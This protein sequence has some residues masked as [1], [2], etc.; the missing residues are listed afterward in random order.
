MIVISSGSD[1]DS[2]IEV[3]SS[4]DIKV[5]SAPPRG[6][7]PA[8][9][10]RPNST[11]VTLG[12]PGSSPVVSPPS[13]GSQP[14][15]TVGAGVPGLDRI[16]VRDGDP[17]S[18]SDLPMPSLTQADILIMN[19]MTA[20]RRKAFLRAKANNPSLTAAKFDR[21]SEET[22][23]KRRRREESK[24]DAIRRE[25]WND[26]YQMAFEDGAQTQTPTQN[27]EQNDSEQNDPQEQTLNNIN[28]LFSDIDEAFQRT[29]S[30]M[31]R[32]GGSSY[33]EENDRKGKPPG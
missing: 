28:L 26:L 8:R 1:T 5:V 11:S 22:N 19:E 14:S 32:M 31:D 23:R 2:D 6:R 33:R 16:R 15:I 25:Q 13:R 29:D 12:D 4:P 7:P 3:L 27:S 9:Y 21:I 18:S 24:K 10:A 20:V 30:M 17:G